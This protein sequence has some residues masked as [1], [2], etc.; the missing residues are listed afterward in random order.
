MKTESYITVPNLDKWQHYKDRCPPW[1]KLHR[2][3]LNDYKLA[4]L[5]DASKAH[6]FA[7]WLLASQMDNK[8]PLDADWIAKKINATEPVALNNL[9]EQGFIEVVQ[10]DSKKIAARKQNA[11]AETETETEAE[12]EA[13]AEVI[14]EPEKIANY[15]AEKIL[16]RDAKYTH[17]IN[18]KRNKA[19]KAWASDIEKINRL[20]SREW[21]DIWRVVEWCLDD[22]FWSKNI[23]SGSKLREK[24]SDLVLKMSPTSQRTGNQSGFA[25]SG[26]RL[27]L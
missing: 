2:E 6:L 24:F 10:P 19:L 17:L 15:M 22:D 4:C 8:I 23:L 20:D 7:I 1:I 26:K 12:A 9:I 21:S 27:I 18:G 11:L 13:E 14:S 3:V 16:S 25:G 5:Q